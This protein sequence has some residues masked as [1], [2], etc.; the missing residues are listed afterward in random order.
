MVIGH[1]M[2][3]DVTC[4]KICPFALKTCYSSHLA[5][6]EPVCLHPNISPLLARGD[7]EHT[8]TLTHTVALKLND[9]RY[10]DLRFVP[11]RKASFHNVTV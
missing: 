2:A 1:V 7:D 10:G 9:G 5:A 11:K 3:V 8:H 6:K 4:E